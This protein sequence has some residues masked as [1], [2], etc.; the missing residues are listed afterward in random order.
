MA[1]VFD[2]VH[3]EGEA[4]EFGNTLL[5]DLTGL[6]GAG[7][8]GT[9]AGEALAVNKDTLMFTSEVNLQLVKN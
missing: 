1:L 3:D 4:V 6:E 2:A 7:A 9:R 8:E 5:G